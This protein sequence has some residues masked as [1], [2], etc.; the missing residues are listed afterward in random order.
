MKET[1]SEVLQIKKELQEQEMLLNGYQLENERLF[2]ELK[3]RDAERKQFH[4]TVIDE[5]QRL[6]KYIQKFF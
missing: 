4:S 1:A 6:S 2:K 3:R 5:N